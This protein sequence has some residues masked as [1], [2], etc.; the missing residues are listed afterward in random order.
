MVVSLTLLVDVVGRYFAIILS[1]DNVSPCVKGADADIVTDVIARD[2][3]AN[4]LLTVDSLLMSDV[5]PSLGRQ[6]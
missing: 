6:C 2:V 5:S 4:I 3:I 1:A